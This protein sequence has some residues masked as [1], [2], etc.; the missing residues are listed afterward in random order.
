M[1]DT[2]FVF[3]A[4]QRALTRNLHHYLG[5][6]G[7]PMF[8]SLS[9]FSYESMILVEWMHNCAGLYKWIMAVTVGPLGDDRARLKADVAHRKQLE[10]NGIFPDLWLNEPV[11]LDESMASILCRMDPE[12]IKRENTAWCRRW[13]RTCGKKV[14]KGTRITAL[15]DQILRWR[16]Y[17]RDNPGQKLVID[18]GY[19]IDNV[20][21]FLTT[22][23][24][25]M[26]HT[27]I[28]LI[29]AYTT[30]IGKKPLPW[31][32]TNIAKKKIDRRV[33]NIVYPHSMNGCS[34]DS[35]SFVL[36]S[37]RAW[38]TAEKLTALLVI[39]PTVLRDYVRC[40][41][42][43]HTHIRAH[44]ITT[45][46]FQIP[47]VRSG[48][49][50]V[51]LGLRILEG[52]C[53]SSNEAAQMRVESGSRPLFEEDIEQAETLIIEGL[54]M[55]EGTYK[56]APCTYVCTTHS[57]DYTFTT[58]CTPIDSLPPC[59]HVFVH[60]ANCARKFGVLTWYWL[61][62]FERYNKKIKSLVGNATHPM[63]S[64]KQALLRDTGIV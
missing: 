19:V 18:K 41:I 35:T 46:I 26:T 42:S 12:V 54:A 61:M 57:F 44:T 31:R 64:L 5:Q 2:V 50:K 8:A 34:K 27:H 33:R 1:K 56:P 58:G 14:Q 16:Q 11:Y 28:I 62:A 22:L 60:Y 40:V 29:N 47:T 10:Q 53:V 49:K 21:D 15:R 3:T 24:H 37:G 4:A 36:Q 48:L 45:H 43:P 63:S 7:L 25:N 51:I 32:L 38:R 20:Y 23:A 52:R 30:H 17:L 13:W 39:L 6:K 59:V 55:L 9:Y